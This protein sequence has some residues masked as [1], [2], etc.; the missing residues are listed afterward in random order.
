MVSAGLTTLGRK[1]AV[2]VGRRLPVG[3][4]MQIFTSFVPRCSE[5]AEGIAEGFTEVGGEVL[6]IDPLPTIV[7]PQVL[8]QAVWNELN[9]NGDNITEFVNRW[10]RGE[11][12]GLMEPF[13]E[14]GLRLEED[15]LKRLF[16]TQEKIILVNVT[17]DLSLMAMKR[18]LFGRELT[19]D[20]REPYLGG[21]GAVKTSTGFDVF[22]ASENSSISIRR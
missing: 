8:E 19:Y 14:Y 3:R 20:D 7:G 15:V 22:I 9:P 13:V 5:T 4:P 2:E 16:D 12:E 10:V 6:D 11:F 18:L 1:L 21:L 17:H